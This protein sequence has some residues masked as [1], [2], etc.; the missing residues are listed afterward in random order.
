MS[1]RIRTHQ[2]YQSDGKGGSELVSEV[3]WP[4]TFDEFMTDLKEKRRAAVDGGIFLDCGGT[5]VFFGTSTNH[6]SGYSELL[7]QAQ[8]VGDSWREYLTQ[9]SASGDRTI[10]EMTLSGL[11]QIVDAVDQH[12]RQCFAMERQYLGLARGGGISLDELHER[13][14]TNW[15]GAN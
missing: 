14:Q 2:F 9:T 15:P 11:R 5:I 6:R 1:G 7:R 4:V 10:V 8:T 3:P 13:M 12:I